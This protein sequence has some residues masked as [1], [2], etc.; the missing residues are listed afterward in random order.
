M[1]SIDFDISGWE[2]AILGK[3]D[4]LKLADGV[5]SFLFYYHRIDAKS[6]NFVLR[7]T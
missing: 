4:I 5:D 3:P 6:E 1:S 7:A 2:R